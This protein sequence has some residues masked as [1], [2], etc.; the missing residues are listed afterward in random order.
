VIKPALKEV[1]ELIS[2]DVSVEYKKENRKVIALK[3]YFKETKT[4]KQKIENDKAIQNYP[5]R[6]KLINEF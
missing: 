1:N 6:D 3:F 4:L 2:F 5:L